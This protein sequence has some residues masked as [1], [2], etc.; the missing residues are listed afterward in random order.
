MIL[1]QIGALGW[2]R[3]LVFFLILWL[4]ILFFAFPML[5]TQHIVQSDSKTAERLTRALSELEA[6][7]KQ[8]VELQELFKDI[9]LG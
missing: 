3:I 9:T 6:L 2:N 4:V 7:R 8:N 5:T 1:R